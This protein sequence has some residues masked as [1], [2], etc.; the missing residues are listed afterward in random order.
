VSINPAFAWNHGYYSPNIDITWSAFVGPSVAARG[1]DG[2]GP[3]GA[4][5]VRDPNSTRTVP[6]ASGRGTWID[7][8]DVRPTMLSLVGLSDDYQTDGRVVTQ[9]LRHAPRAL[10]NTTD[11][12]ACY[13]QLNSAVG[14]FGTD[15]LIADTRALASGSAGS[16]PQFG[17][18]EARLTRL[19]DRR[20]ALSTRIK[21]ALSAA[22]FQD[23]TPR[24][25]TVRS[26]AGRCFGLLDE[27]ARL[28]R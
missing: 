21:S 27:A 4:P 23:K 6:E 14:E 11:L 3:A 25:S 26:Q 16:D 18:T 17:A 9:I 7:E 1:V 24:R 28:L 13:K 12:A 2:P 19:A 15:T 22:A 20:D 10:K 8:T 5:E